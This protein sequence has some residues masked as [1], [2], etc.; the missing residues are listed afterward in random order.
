MILKGI[1]YLVLALVSA[2]AA[3]AAAAEQLVNF[4]LLVPTVLFLTIS[5]S[6][7]FEK[8]FFS[9]QI[10]TDVSSYR[11]LTKSSVSFPL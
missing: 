8:W 7:L 4:V 6:S 9:Q 10:S 1:S 3:A 5:L 11:S 2:A